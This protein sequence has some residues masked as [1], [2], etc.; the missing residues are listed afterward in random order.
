VFFTNSGSEANDTVVKLLWYRNNALGKPA[1]KKFISRQNA[2]HGTTT[3][4]ASLTGLPANQRGFDVPLPG[5]LHVSCPHF[6]RYGRAGET[7]EQFADRLAR[8]LDDLIIKEGPET[9]AAFYGEPLMGAGGVIIPPKTYWEKIQKV[10]RKHDVLIVA[11]EVICGFGRTGNMFGCETFDIKPDVM[12]VSKQLSSSYQP[13]A[14]IL[15]ND[16]VYQDIADQSQSIG[17]LGHGFTGSGHPVATA[18]ALEN[19]K[20]IEEEGL[21]QHAA[22][23]GIILRK[24][25]QQF[26]DHPM[27]GEVRGVGLIAAVELVADRHTK[28]P[29]EAVGRLGR[30]LSSQ[31]QER[32]M[33]NRVMGDALAF[34]P[35]LISVEKDIN[36]ILGV[37]AS[38][39]DATQHWFLKHT[40]Q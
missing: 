17:T 15:I 9:V 35:P 27:V 39:L 31:T 3:V 4:S 38:S 34:C 22:E 7:E 8:E 23:M 30:Y 24:G 11:D 1:K 40:A 16:A 10:C 14:A 25:L 33:I 13:I 2:Y 29:F 26:A 18:V 37:F 19:L 21:V 6:Y 28:E 5:F 32:G 12:V 20:I 36:E